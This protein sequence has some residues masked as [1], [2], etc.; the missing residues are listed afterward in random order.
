M[1][2]YL[3]LALLALTVAGGLVAFV[4]VTKPVPAHAEQYPVSVPHII[5][6][7]VIFEAIDFSSGTFSF[8]NHD[9]ELRTWPLPIIGRNS[10]KGA[11]KG[12]YVLL[13]IKNLTSAIP[14][15]SDFDVDKIIHKRDTIAKGW[16][17]KLGII[18]TA[19]AQQ[20]NI[21]SCYGGKFN[22]YAISCGSTGGKCSGYCAQGYCH[23]VSFPGEHGFHCGC[24]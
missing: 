5:T 3:V 10:L 15:A 6:V 12:D 19:E 24:K 16:L 7:A 18:S 9:G 2:K 11:I 1:R 21:C 23:E 20:Q 4:A 22:V 14:S 17:Q 8:Q 13:E